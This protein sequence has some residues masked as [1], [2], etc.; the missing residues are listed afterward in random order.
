[1]PQGDGPIALF[2]RNEDTGH[3]FFPPGR[4]LRQLAPHNNFDF[5]EE[6]MRQALALA[7]CCIVLAPAPAL[8]ALPETQGGSSHISVQINGLAVQGVSSLTNLTS[9]E[10][11]VTGPGLGAQKT[12]TLVLTRLVTS[13]EAFRQWDENVKSG[14]PDRRS[15]AITVYNSAGEAQG[16][17][18]FKNCLPIAYIAAPASP[19]KTGTVKETIKLA[20]ESEQWNPK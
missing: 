15:V 14:Q 3:G 8:F 6:V 9:L 18:T 20:Y 2:M 11:E 1:M 17:F 16:S 4:P 13:S 19:G 5:P 10:K 12:K 7:V